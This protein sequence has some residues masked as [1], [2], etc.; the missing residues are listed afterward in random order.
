MTKEWW[1]EWFKNNEEYF[2]EHYR[3]GWAIM[4]KVN[5]DTQKQKGVYSGSGATKYCIIDETCNLVFKWSTNLNYNEMEKECTLYQEAVSEGIE[6]F[7]PKTEQFI[8][9]GK[10]CVYVQERVSSIYCDLR[11]DTIKT[12]SETHHTVTQRIMDKAYRGFENP[13]PDLW[14]RMA[15]SYFGKRRVQQ[16]CKFTRKHHINDLHGANVGFQGVSNTPIILDFSG[17]S[18]S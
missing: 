18:R 14:I 17:Y 1:L 2:L 9:Y 8:D 11:R 10:M 13:P 5:A 12:L 4:D 6:C 7:F 3:S 15:I 16:L